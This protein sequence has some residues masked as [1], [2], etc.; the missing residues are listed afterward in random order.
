M[1]GRSTPGTNS[2]KSLSWGLSSTREADVGIIIDKGDSHFKEILTDDTV[3]PQRVAIDSG[4]SHFKEIL[5]DDTN[6]VTPLGV[7][8]GS[9][10]KRGD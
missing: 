2:A 5:T 1:T 9:G 4:G 3:N 7:V 6:K 10:S 8:N